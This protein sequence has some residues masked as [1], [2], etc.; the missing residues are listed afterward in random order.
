MISVKKG[1]RNILK[2]MIDTNI[3]LD[4]LLDRVPF[5]DYAD[6]IIKLS[7]DGKITGMITASSATDIYY[8]LRKI[9]GHDRAIEAL[10]T[11]FLIFDVTDVGKP[12]LLYA[13]K[14][15]MSDYEDAV[16]ASC[17]KKIKADY[18]I[19]RNPK[20]FTLSP[21]QSILPEEFINQ[22]DF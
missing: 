1:W 11:I 6:K 8:V 5:A 12:D 16:L 7:E 10:N 2:I 22:F 13:I 9:I 14:M 15:R 19:T 21:V 17:A 3:I 20:H 4:H 18:I